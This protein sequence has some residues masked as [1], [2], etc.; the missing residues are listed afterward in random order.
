MS[1]NPPMAG[2]GTAGAAPPGPTRTGAMAPYGSTLA[3]G[4]AP[5]SS[6]GKR[7][8][9]LLLDGLLAVLTL[10]IGWLIWALI[11][12]SK[13]Q[14]PGK[15][16]LGMRCVRT[17]TG[18]AATWGTMALREWVGKGLIG[19]ASC[20]ITNLVSAFMILGPARQGVWDKIAATVVVDDPEG[21][22]LHR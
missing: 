7:F 8:G 9:A 2:P 13:G 4:G 5:M 10:Y 1:G 16:L 11:V 3:V 17:D 19:G 20:G 22:L 12:W 18:L 15:S 14:S 6:A 21:R